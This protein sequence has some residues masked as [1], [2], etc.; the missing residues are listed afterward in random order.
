MQKQRYSIID[1]SFSLRSSKHSEMEHGYGIEYQNKQFHLLA[2][3]CQ[4]P[5]DRPSGLEG[6]FQTNT[7]ILQDIDSDLIVFT[8]EKYI[9][10][11]PEICPHCGQAI[12]NQ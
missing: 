6:D 3:G 10:R 5:A 1:G 8:Q 4:L 12:K 2:K 9:R 7:I 11:V